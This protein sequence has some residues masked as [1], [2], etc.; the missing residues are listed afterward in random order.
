MNLMR[1]TPVNLLL[2][3]AMGY[4]M[5]GI[6]LT[7]CVS[8]LLYDQ[9]GKMFALKDPAFTGIKFRND[10]REDK[11]NNVIVYQD[12]YSGGGVSIGDINNDGLADIFLTG[13]MVPSRLYLNKGGFKFEDFTQKAGLGNMGKGWYTGT[14]MADINNDG[15]LDIYISKSG[16]YSPGDRRN[17]LYINNGN[18]TFT[19]RGKEYGL[20]FPGYSVN[21]TFFD[22]DNDGDLD[23]Y[24]VNQG[25]E[26]FNSGEVSHLREVNHP[27]CG[28]NLF[29]NRGGRFIDVTDSA[30]IDS[31]VIGFGHGVS[32][33][34]INDAGW[35]DIFVS[36]D[37]FEH[38]Y[39][40]FN[41]HDKTFRESIATATKH[42]SNYSMG[43]DL[44]D[45]NNDGLLDIVVVDMVAEDNRRLQANLG[46]MGTNKFWYTVNGG[47]H[48]QYMYNM[49][50]LNNGNQI[51]SE[52]GQLAGISNTDWSWGPLFADFDDDGFKDLYVTNGIRKDIRNIDWGMTYRQM[53]RKSYGK[54]EFTDNE[55]DLLLKSMPSEKIINYMYRNNGNLTY[56]KVMD[57]WGMKYPSFSNGGAY[58]DLDNDGD[59]DLVVNNV[60]EEAFVFENKRNEQPGYHYLKIKLIGPEKNR[61][62]L[63]TKVRLYDHGRL[64]YQQFYLTRGYRSSMDPYLFFGLGPDSIAD[65]ILITWPGGRTTQLENIAAN[66]LL[67]VD[68]KDS[69]GPALVGKDTTQTYFADYTEASGLICRHTE[70]EFDDFSKQ[71]LLPYKLSNLGPGLAAGDVNGDGLDDIYIGGAFRY[72]GHLFLQNRN[73]TFRESSMEPWK[74]DRMYEDMGAVFFDAEN[75]G[76]P[77]L[78]VVSGGNEFSPHSSYY[79]DRLYINNGH[80]QFRKATRALPMITES[81][82]CVVPCDYDQDGDLDLFVGGRLIPWKYPYPASSHLLKNDHGIFTDVTADLAPGLIELGMVTGAVWSDYDH[83]GDKDLILAGEWMPITLFNN[84]NGKLNK[85]TE[86]NGLENTEGWWWSIAAF[87]FDRDGDEDFVAGNQGLNIKY[88]ATPGQ[89]FEIYAADFDT[90]GTVDIALG[91][92]SDHKLYPVRNRAASYGQIPDIRNR[93]PTNDLY[94]AM[95]LP[96]IYGEKAL[97]N[98]IHYSARTFASSYIENLGH[99][100]FRVK[101]LDNLAQFTNQNSILVTDVDGDNNMDFIMAGNLYGLE[102]ET[103]RNDAGTGIWMRGDGKGNFTGIPCNLSGLYADGDIKDGKLISTGHGRILVYARNNDEVKVIRILD[104]QNSFIPHKK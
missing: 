94:A 49:L 39:L 99:G 82:S 7:S 54:V 20:D 66:Q 23:M 29:E 65:K 59:L 78:Y 74:D 61:L 57:D 100:K 47:F 16:M 32:A 72:P 64:Q 79:Q 88:K 3:F 70:D 56:S 103:T 44:A 92:Y 4:V 51:F 97:Q 104:H 81:G 41:N 21:A 30:R 26:K 101:P 22:Y 34:D 9:E 36:N 15:F 63:G 14:T 8:R 27:Y 102:V 48:Y 10:L 93:I 87:D 25:P 17:L 69:S 73:G 80:G 67:T 37:F 28:D 42:I 95:T 90:S 52:I 77:D 60:D 35:E 50:H 91:W 53:L 85:V 43:N 98:A 2:N 75:D 40:Y 6:L 86:N 55:W 68:F 76:D 45:F 31:S 83:D 46:G 19:E 58:G 11:F 13:N 33:G 96:E 89:P 62:G 24:L 18:G 5:S 38:D 84:H 12:F 1:K 71:T